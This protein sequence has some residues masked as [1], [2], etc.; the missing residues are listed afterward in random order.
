MRDTT[1][2]RM[3]AAIARRLKALGVDRRV[4]LRALWDKLAGITLTEC[5]K[6]IEDHRQLREACEKARETLEGQAAIYAKL[7]DEYLNL[8]GKTMSLALLTEARRQAAK[9]ETVKERN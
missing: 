1:I 4:L 5:E 8:R 7:R 6:H 9:M 3:P 2:I